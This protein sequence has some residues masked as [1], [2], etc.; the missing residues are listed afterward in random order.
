LRAQVRAPHSIACAGLTRCCREFL[1][2]RVGTLEAAEVRTI[3]NRSACHK[4][5][6]RLRRSAAL[7]LRREGRSRRDRRDAGKYKD[8]SLHLDLLV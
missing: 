1:A 4:K 3:P 8:T 6:H 2:V 7:T 5:A